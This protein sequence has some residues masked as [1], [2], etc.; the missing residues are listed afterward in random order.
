MGGKLGFWG[1][2]GPCDLR[3]AWCTACGPAGLWG[4]VPKA[5]L[6]PAAPP[7]VPPLKPSV[8]PP[9][10]PRGPASRNPGGPRP[11]ARTIRFDMPH[12]RARSRA[13]IRS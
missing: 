10:T 12:S 9:R 7:S 4:P 1:V 11:P 2:V 13:L 3:S 5:A 6:H 8:P